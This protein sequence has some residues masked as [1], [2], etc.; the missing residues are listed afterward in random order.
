[1][2]KLLLDKFE[3]SARSVLPVGVI[4]FVL[5][6][7]I[8]PMPAGTL[9]LFVT[10]MV[11]LVLGMGIFT[12][13]SD[14]AM[15]P[16]GERI[17][18]EL[19]RSR[20]VWVLI[21]GGF[22]LGVV[23]TVAEPDLQVLT[24][25]VPSVPDRVLIFS[26]AVGVGVS[27][28]AAL[29]RILLQV[30]LSYLLI[31]LYGVAFVLAA[32]TSP[33]YL[34]VAFD[35]GG[36]TT[37]PVTVPFILSLGA[38]VSAVRSGKSAEED[39]FGL[40]AV[41][42]IGPILSV[43][44]IGMF[45]DPAGVGYG[46][47]TAESVNSMRELLALYGSGFA[48]FAKETASALLPIAVIFGGFQAVRLK[49]PKSQVI[50]IAIGLLYTFVGLT[51]FMTGVNIGF[52][53]A[54]MYLGKSIAS[55]SNNWILLPLSLLIGFFVVAAEPA[56]HVLNKQV[57]E[58]TSGAISRRM[59]MSGL[60]IG[61]GL[62]LVLAMLRIMTRVSIWFFLVPGYAIAL[63]LTFFVSDVFTAIAFD[64]GGVAAGSMAAAFLLPF[65]MGACNA[66]GGNIMTDAF[67][68]IAMVA[69][70][71]L[72]TVQIMGLLYKLKM[73]RADAEEAGLAMDAAEEDTDLIEM[74]NEE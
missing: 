62:A 46:F 29:L 58:I 21:A 68:I 48:L 41:C 35:S 6:L 34:A 61:V 55:L 38:G 24:K 51:V 1:M 47:E 57:E 69:M 17:G 4:V 45:Y 19:T 73:R 5:H 23:V 13:G 7:T 40:C 14:M 63:A 66:L 71:P 44:I 64:S 54:G 8:S 31:A 72:I 9:L 26:V 18:S 36:V 65:A 70:L 49:L 56:V 12:L 11:L 2:G 53:P 52:M 20:K 15:M 22:L 32:F 39:S 43:L 67:G 28:V 37:G 60:S 16:I 3:E 30:R 50:K 10:G 27:L 74:R 59:M 33:D 25:Q 42:S